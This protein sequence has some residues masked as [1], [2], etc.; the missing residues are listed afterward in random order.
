MAA[1][2]KI[3]DNP[4]A[5]RS[6]AAVARLDEESVASLRGVTAEM[7]E[8][9][10]RLEAPNDLRQRLLFF[11]S[12]LATSAIEF[13]RFAKSHDGS[14]LTVHVEMSPFAAGLLKLLRR[15]AITHLDL[16]ALMVTT[17]VAA[18]RQ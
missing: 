4:R 3:S 5:W 13:C 8:L 10:K 1:A 12:C 11:L 17:L 6:G 7:G 15:G 9:L 18:R 14:I 2:E 16:D